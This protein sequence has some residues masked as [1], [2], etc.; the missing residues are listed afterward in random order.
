[1]SKTN[2]SGRS[3]RRNRAPSPERLM[4][5][6]PSE[7]R[8]DPARSPAADPRLTRVHLEEKPSLKRRFSVRLDIEIEVDACLLAD[9]LTDEWQQRFYPLSTAEAVAGHLAYNL[10]QDRRLSSL[11]GFADQHE[12]AACILDACV[13]DSEEIALTRATEARR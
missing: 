1:M 4:D 7:S 9:V 3:V 13:D 5:R 6:T 8:P 10:I 11:D 2:V 12:G